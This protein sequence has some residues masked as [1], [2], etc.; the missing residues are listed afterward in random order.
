MAKPERSH[1]T[2]ISY[3]LEDFTGE[4]DPKEVDLDISTIS[5]DEL[6]QLIFHVPEAVSEIVYREL[7]G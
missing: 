7:Y 1:K 4:K 3:Y 6:S 2:K 5:D